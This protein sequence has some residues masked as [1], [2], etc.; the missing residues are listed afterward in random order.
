V[1][2]SRVLDKLEKDNFLLFLVMGNSYKFDIGWYARVDLEGR[3]LQISVVGDG[4]DEVFIF[5]WDVW[6]V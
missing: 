5:G 2:L 6:I 3:G 4:S 1:Q